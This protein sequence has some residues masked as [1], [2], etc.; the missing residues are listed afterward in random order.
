MT[1]RNWK[2]FHLPEKLHSGLAVPHLLNDLE[3]LVSS[4][5]ELGIKTNGTRLHRYH[6]YL[7]AAADGDLIDHAFYFADLPDTHIR[8][9][10]DLRLYIFR[11]V[12]E[13]VWIWN[14]IKDNTPIGATEKLKQIVG[15][16]DFTPSDDDSTSRNYQYEL[17][18]ASYFCRRKYS[19]D[20]SRQ[21]DIVAT[22]ANERFFIECKR[23][24]SEKQ[25]VP[26]LN[27]AAKQLKKSMP[28][29]SNTYGIIA[30]DL[31]QVAYPG[32]K[33]PVGVTAG[34]LKE[35]IQAKLKSI[36]CSWAHSK[37]AQ[38]NK[39]NILIWKQVQIMGL[40]RYPFQPMTRVS[41]LFSPS[42]SMSRRKKRAFHRLEEVLHSTD[43][44]D[45]RI[46][47]D[48]S[49]TP[50]QY[51]MLEAGTKFAWDMELL[52]VISSDL[53]LPMIEKDH[54]V[55]EVC[56]RDDEWEQFYI[57]D[58]TMALNNLTLEQRIS[59]KG[60]PERA[61]AVLTAAMIYWRDPYDIRPTTS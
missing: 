20:V 16:R 42:P 32:S 14:G 12:H 24:S 49:V 43:S 29:S 11:E 6:R 22:S 45:P 44:N 21:T 30:L 19:V 46:E 52:K 9:E 18:I 23:L 61:M 15:G 26:K 37:T 41:N 56:N 58:L 3:A 51:A 50:R 59:I 36:P 33:Y 5:N 2:R 48:R 7:K 17:R 55:L 38:D 34:D 47:P 39:Q 28:R 60:N 35:S 8:D 57:D 27:D 1:E 13:L 10:V 40:A 25:V 54:I 53:A 31:T 4:M